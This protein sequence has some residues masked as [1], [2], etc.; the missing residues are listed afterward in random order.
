MA[1]QSFPIL[2]ITG[3]RIGDAILSSG[4]LKRLYDEIPNA[5]F[6]IAVGPPAAPLFADMPRV[7]RI[8][9][10]EKKPFSGHWFALWRIARRTR[11][12]L[13]VDLR[14]SAISSF[15]R[16][17][18]RAVFRKAGEDEVLHKVV[19]AARV[20]QMEAEPP[21]PYLFTSADTEAAAT[22]YLGA[23]GP[24]LAIAPGANWPGKAW[25]AER[26]A[27]AATRLLGEDGPLPNGR[28]L[29]LGSEADRDGGQTLKLAVTRDRLIGVPGQI[30][31]LTSYACLKRARL[32]IGNDSGAMH[33]AAAAG[34]P[35]LG[36]FGPS[37]DRLYA[38]WGPDARALRG[39]REFEVIRQID[40]EL[41][42]AVCHM[43]DLPVGWVVE[44]ATK[45]LA[46]T[47]ANH[48]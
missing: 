34:I 6:T 15:L 35:T 8:V 43:F 3:S 12:G 46:E 32:F 16:R 24:I 25:P 30:D 26:F 11:W 9:V 45:L 29:V 23:G 48:G 1:E 37:D 18:R 2:F 4:L 33:L 19:E 31:L 13:I 40:P 39:P 41:N 17:R 38:P 42:Q 28:L 7:D 22:A 27:E 36:L 10:L 14:G 21:F 20:L 5:R 47:E 44:A